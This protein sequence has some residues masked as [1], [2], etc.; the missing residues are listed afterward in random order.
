V[1]IQSLQAVQLCCGSSSQSRELCFDISHCHV[2]TCVFS[3]LYVTL[4][5]SDEHLVLDGEDTCKQI[6][7]CI[8]IITWL[9]TFLFNISGSVFSPAVPHPRSQLRAKAC[10][11]LEERRKRRRLSGKYTSIE[12]PLFQQMLSR[13]AHILCSLTFPTLYF[14]PS[15]AI[16]SLTNLTLK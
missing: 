10:H 13:A 9:N 6:L 7:F 3:S 12:R 14:L 5:H 2:K 15:C 11:A 4:V 16:L 8:V 1:W